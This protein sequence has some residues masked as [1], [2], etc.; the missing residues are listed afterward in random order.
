MVTIA[1]DDAVRMPGERLTVRDFDW[2]NSSDSNVYIR[3]HILVI[4]KSSNSCYLRALTPMID[5]LMEALVS[6]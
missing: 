3:H 1:R 2:T 6:I 4:L 5:L